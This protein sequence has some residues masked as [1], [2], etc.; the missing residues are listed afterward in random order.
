MFYRIALSLSRSLSFLFACALLVVQLLLLV[1]FHQN[2]GVALLSGFC[3]SNIIDGKFCVLPWWASHFIP[4]FAAALIVYSICRYRVL[5]HKW[6]L[7]F[8][9]FL[10]VLLMVLLRLAVPLIHADKIVWMDMGYRAKAHSLTRFPSIF[11]WRDD[12]ALFPNTS[13]PWQAVS[14]GATSR[15]S[16]LRP[17]HV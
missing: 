15:M 17:K 11:E 1:D 16:C 5:S 9:P 2:H 4:C 8:L 7:I 6:W 14:G 12:V 13:R 3:A 10:S